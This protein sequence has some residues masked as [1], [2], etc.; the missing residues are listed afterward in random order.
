MTSVSARFLKL[1]DDVS[2]VVPGFECALIV[3]RDRKDFPE[4]RNLAYCAADGGAHCP[5]ITV[6]PDLADRGAD[7]VSAILQHELG[8][9][10]DF[11]IGAVAMRRLLYDQGFDPSRLGPERRA[12]AFAELL[13]GR[14]IRYDQN[15]V[16]TFGVGISPRPRRLGL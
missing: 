1:C 6:A 3:A 2:A 8:H 5:A 15:D 11:V 9:A 10:V 4:W 12:D 13:W 7:T 16:Q 14:P